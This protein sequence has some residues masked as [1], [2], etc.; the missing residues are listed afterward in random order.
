MILIPQNRTRI[1]GCV[2]INAY[3]GDLALRGCVPDAKG[4]RDAGKARGWQTKMLLDGDATADNGRAFIR[5]VLS[6]AKPGDE[7]IIAWSSHGA[8]GGLLCPVDFDWSD[9]HAI[10]TAYLLKVL[11]DVP[12]GV[13][14]TFIFDTC[15]SGAVDGVRDLSRGRLRKA[16]FFGHRPDHAKLSHSR[17]VLATKLPARVWSACGSGQ[18]SADASDGRG[19]FY[20]AFSHAAQSALRRSMLAVAGSLDSMNTQVKRVL[21]TD[22][23]DQIPELSGSRAACIRPLFNPS[24]R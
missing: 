4:W 12:A 16:R 15:Y 17:E 9:E 21:A 3:P 2:G 19:N 14:V 22:D 8:E 18:T 6:G 20:G 7:R 23:F 13:Q 10:G 24:R 5:E 1:I 11:A